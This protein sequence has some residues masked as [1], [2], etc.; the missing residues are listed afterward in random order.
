MGP[1]YAAALALGAAIACG[2]EDD[3]RVPLPPPSIPRHGG[4]ELAAAEDAAAPLAVLLFAEGDVQLGRGVPHAGLALERGERLRVGPGSRAEVELR[5]GVRLGLEAGTDLRL[6]DIGPAHVLLIAGPLHL[7]RPP[8]EGPQPVVRLATREAS[9]VI[10]SEGEFLVVESEAGASATVALSGRSTVA[11]GEFDGRGRL[12]ELELTAGHAVLVDAHLGEPIATATDLPSAQ[13]SAAALLAGMPALDD[14]H[15]RRDLGAA[16]G[17]L[18]EA[19]GALEAEARR[20][21]AL[22]LGHREAVASAEH[23]EATRLGEDLAAHAAA[24]H[25]LREAATARWE[26]VSVHVLALENAPAPDP[27]EVRAERIRGLLGE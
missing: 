14:E 11:S 25:R 12:R 24:L 4:V 17:R 10:P 9:I 18:D 26:R 1:R 6:G 27:A 8:R 5:E 19:L 16:I 20:G 22:T 21:G 15:R 2:G 3:R 7:T 23:D 13:A